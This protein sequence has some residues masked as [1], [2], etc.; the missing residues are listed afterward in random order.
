MNAAVEG[1]QAQ[2]PQATRQGK[3]AAGNQKQGNGNGG[4]GRQGFQ[5]GSM[6]S[7]RSKNLAMA[8][9]PTKPNMLISKAMSKYSAEPNCKPSTSRISMP[10]MYMVSSASTRSVEA[11]P[12]SSR[13]AAKTSASTKHPSAK[14]A[15]Q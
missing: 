13:R 2:K 9:D 15:A 12:C 14:V 11:G 1:G 3:K 8:T 7:P 10:L 4:P 6:T 5:H